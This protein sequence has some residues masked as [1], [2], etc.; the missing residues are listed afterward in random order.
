MKKIFGVLLLF[1]LFF[2][3]SACGRDD[4]DTIRYVGLQ[5]YDPVYIAVDRGMYEEA[6]L[7]VQVKST[8]MGGP[9]GLQA[10]SSGE[11]H[12]TLSSVMAIINAVNA[13]LPVIGVSDIQS[14]LE[15]MPL[16]EF[17]VRKDSG[18]ESIEDVKGKTIGINLT[19]SSF[20]YTWLI[21]FEDMPFDDDDVNFVVMS[22]AD[23]LTAL[24]R[25]NID[26]ASLMTPHNTMARDDDD[27]KMIFT[28]LDIFGEKQFSTH[29]L[30]SKWAEEN[31]DLAETFVRVTVE[32]MWWSQENQDEAAEIISAYTGVDPKY[33]AEYY[34]QENGKVAEDD[35]KYWLEYMQDVEGIRQDLTWEDVATNRYNPFVED[36]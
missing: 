30:N 24:K 9:D 16:E 12:G 34:F 31:P 36:E 19:R 3:I 11:A 25:D 26:V 14:S 28:A 22:F 6:G 10:V 27:L 17:F 2:S 21:A 4:D 15:E 1:V 18:I 7:D 35:I 8:S 13:G 5:I 20:H 32:A 33:I 29:V 23:Q